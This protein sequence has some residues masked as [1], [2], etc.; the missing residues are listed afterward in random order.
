M[1]ICDYYL[2]LESVNC[3]DPDER[4]LIHSYYRDMLSYFE[5]NPNSPFSISIFNTLDKAGYIK[6]I[7]IERR[8]EK[9]GDLING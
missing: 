3:L 4:D 2:D 9:L 6:N 8:E 5:S 7:R 1:N